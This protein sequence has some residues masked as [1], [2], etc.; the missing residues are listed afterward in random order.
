M[1]CGNDRDIFY[2]SKPS[3]GSWSQYE[4]VSDNSGNSNCPSIDCA[5]GQINVVWMDDTDWEDCGDDNDIFFS[6]YALINN[7]ISLLSRTIG[8]IKLEKIRIN[9]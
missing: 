6:K 5:Y 2:V 1:G 9:T 3:G 7:K 4:V 8:L